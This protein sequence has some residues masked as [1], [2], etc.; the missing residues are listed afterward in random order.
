[1]AT[2]LKAGA[3]GPRVLA[4]QKLLVHN[5][6]GH[7]FYHGRL[8]GEF[9]WS[10]N[11]G[12]TGQACV[13]AKWRLGYAVKSCQ[14]VAG[15]LLI[16]YLSGKRVPT[17]DMKARTHRR[18]QPKPEPPAKTLQQKAWAD[19]HAHLGEH[20]SPP[21]SNH[22]PDTVEWGHGDMA[23]CGV[24]CSLAYIHAG[25]SVAFSKSAG[26]FQYVPGLLESAR[27][28]HY[29]LSIT[30]SPMRGDL[31]VWDYPPTGGADHVTMFG[32]WE[33]GHTIFSDIGGNEGSSGICKADVNHRTYVRAFIRVKGRT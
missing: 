25:E 31:V 28:G 14:P 2:V 22:C 3:A 5:V 1:M 30:K 11:G 8:D 12:L 10:G 15:A 23:W 4:L 20:E 27:Q 24:R 13:R 9:G 6:T 16:A 7:M 19:M 21:G 18:A 32:E 17:A 33:E 29:G 26:R